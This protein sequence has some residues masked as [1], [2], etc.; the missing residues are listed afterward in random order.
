MSKTKIDPCLRLAIYEAYSGKCFYTGKPVSYKDF[1]VDH[2]IPESQVADFEIIKK[3]LKVEDD[4]DINS[5]ENLV[6]CEPGINRDKRDN[7]FSDNTLLLY[8]EQTKAKKDR[9]MQLYDRFKNEGK[10]GN[11]YKAIDRTLATGDDK[12]DEIREYIHTKIIERWKEKKITL[13]TPILFSDRELREV[14][15]NENHDEI[16]TKVLELFDDGQGVNLKHDLGEEVEV[17]SLSEWKEYIG[18]GFYPYTNADIKMSGIFEYIDGLINALNIAQ[19]PKLSFLEGQNMKDL[20]TRLSVST[21]IDL[22]K[23]ADGTT[24]GEL[25]KDGKAEI[26]KIEDNVV[27]I[28]YGGFWNTISEEFRADFTDDGI[29]NIFCNVWRNADGGTMGWGETMI[30]GCHSKDGIVEIELNT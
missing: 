28:L 3:R 20:I 24:I 22:E 7:L 14:T 12:L 9:V 19:M 21:L 26:E 6:P 16:M 30:L 1:E 15:I 10:L 29:E 5:I 8:F 23:H 4:F 18:K 17:H 13:N 2:V 11:V 27:R 25:I